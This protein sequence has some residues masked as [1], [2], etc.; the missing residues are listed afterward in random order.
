MTTTITLTITLE[1]PDGA[2]VAVASPGAAAVVAALP[3]PAPRPHLAV[4]P[5]VDDDLPDQ[6]PDSLYQRTCQTCGATFKNR[7]GR[8]I[9]NGRVHGDRLDYA[10]IAA[11]IDARRAAEAQPEGEEATAP[12]GFETYRRQRPLGDLQRALLEALASRHGRISDPRGGATGRLAELAGA[13]CA[14]THVNTTLRRLEELGHLERQVTGRRCFRITL[15]P[16]GWDAIGQTPPHS[17]TIDTA[18]AEPAA[19]SA[20][21]VPRMPD[22]GPIERRRFDPDDV[23]RRQAELV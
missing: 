23:R 17:S 20:A 12:A 19:P 8:L 11:G 13:T 22:L 18:S 5:P 4:A 10:A 9:H 16:G 14:Q 6:H 15:T 1:V 21:D 2:Q 7:N 3:E